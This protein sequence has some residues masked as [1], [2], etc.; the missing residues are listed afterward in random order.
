MF[1][2][3]P[4]GEVV[5]DYHSEVKSNKEGQA[6]RAAI[7]RMTRLPPDQLKTLAPRLASPPDAKGKQGS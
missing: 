3:T 5:W 7:Y 2:V 1:E 6:Q 4:A